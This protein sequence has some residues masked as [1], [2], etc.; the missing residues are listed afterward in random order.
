MARKLASVFC[1]FGFC[2]LTISCTKLGRPSPTGPLK[3]ERAKFTDAIPSEYGSLVA[4]TANSQNPAWV[5]LWF[6]KPDGS[7]VA[8]FVDVADGRINDNALSIPR[9]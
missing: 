5:Y 1:I 2:L 6:Q 9:R 4:V 7:V 8:I 3:Y